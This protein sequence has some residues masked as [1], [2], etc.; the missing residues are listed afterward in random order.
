MHTRQIQPDNHDAP[1]GATIGNCSCFHVKRSR[2]M[3]LTSKKMLMQRS[4]SGKMMVDVLEAEVE[5]SLPLVGLEIG[6]VLFFSRISG[7]PRKQLTFVI[8]QEGEMKEEGTMVALEGKM[9]AFSEARCWG[10]IYN[11]APSLQ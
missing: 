6:L 2:M 7:L 10:P 8:L 5:S 4:M 11:I 9:V 1:Q 3:F